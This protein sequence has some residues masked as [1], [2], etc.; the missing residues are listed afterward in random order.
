MRRSRTRYPVMTPVLHALLNLKRAGL[1]AQC[2]VQFRV[3][4]RYQI[5]SAY[6]N[7]VAPPMALKLLKEYLSKHFG[8]DESWMTATL[9]I[10]LH[11]L[12][13][14]ATGNADLQSLVGDWTGICRRA[15]ISLLTPPGSGV[16]F[17]K[18]SNGRESF[19]STRAYV[20]S[21]VFQF[22]FRFSKLSTQA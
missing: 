2:G 11:S 18:A 19:V 21:H 8:V 20:Y 5:W 10:T 15:C 9:P 3:T 17:A 1:Q 7:V 14:L 6:A 12:L 22:V 4:V 13:P 16:A